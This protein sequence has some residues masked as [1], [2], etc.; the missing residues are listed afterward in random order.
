MFEEL[1]TLTNTTTV[2]KHDIFS[3]CHFQ[4]TSSFL[5]LIYNALRDWYDLKLSWPAKVLQ[6]YCIWQ[7]R[8]KEKFFSWKDR[9]K[10]ECAFNDWIIFSIM[11]N[12][13]A[14]ASLFQIL[15]CPTSISSWLRSKKHASSLFCK[16]HQY[17]VGP[18]RHF[19]VLNLSPTTYFLLNFAIEVDSNR[20]NFELI[21]IHF[22]EY[23]FTFQINRIANFRIESNEFRTNPSS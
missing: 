4:S 8:Q 21:C 23:F 15:L 20:T 14:K 10:Y 2:G 16:G 9:M 3:S 12:P 7:I 22:F 18:Y 5:I 1:A 17:T 11:P 19:L 6:K 13:L